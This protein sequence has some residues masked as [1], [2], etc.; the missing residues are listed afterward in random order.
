MSKLK[1]KK[2][3]GKVHKKKKKKANV[4]KW[5]PWYIH[6][7]FKQEELLKNAVYQEYQN[8]L[9]LVKKIVS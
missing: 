1:K 2:E 5:K 6:E 4:V 7:V 9:S 3:V 8:K